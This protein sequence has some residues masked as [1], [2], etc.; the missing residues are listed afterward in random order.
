MSAISLPGERPPGTITLVLSFLF[1]RDAC[2]RETF[3]VKVPG[4]HA[5]VVGNYCLGYSMYQVLFFYIPNDH[6]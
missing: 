3:L 6:S 5:I 4:E 1:V 2:V